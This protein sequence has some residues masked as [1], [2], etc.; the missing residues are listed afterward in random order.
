MSNESN[1]LVLKK[2]VPCQACE[3]RGYN[4]VMIGERSDYCGVMNESC[5]ECNGTGAKLVDMTNAD[6]IRAMSDEELATFLLNADEGNLTVDICEG[7]CSEQNDCPH[8][9]KAAVLNY[10][11][12][13]ARV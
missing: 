10:L 2:S 9:C 5:P 13:L 6:R 4:T 8:D 1:G 12:S 3:G 7:Y 11:Q